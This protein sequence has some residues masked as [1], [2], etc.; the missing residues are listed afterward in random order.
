[1]LLTLKDRCWPQFWGDQGANLRS[2]CYKSVSHWIS[3][4]LLVSLKFGFGSRDSLIL[5]PDG[6]HT[7]Y[8][9]LS[10][11]AI[12]S[13]KNSCFSLTIFSGTFFPIHFR[14]HRESFRKLGC[15]ATVFSNGERIFS[16]QNMSTLFTAGLLPFQFQNWVIQAP[17]KFSPGIKI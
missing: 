6:C 16:F 9:A 13:D 15:L 1:M 17:S 4:S 7:Q 14:K 2:V 10:F 12:G 11:P 8:T 5:M 3:G